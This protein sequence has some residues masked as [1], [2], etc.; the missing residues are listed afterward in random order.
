[1]PIKRVR[2]E[3]EFLR[4]TH[5][6]PDS[7]VRQP[8]IRRP[9]WIGFHGTT[10]VRAE[11]IEAEGVIRAFKALSAEEIGVLCRVGFDLIDFAN[12]RSAFDFLLQE[13]AAFSRRVGTVNFFSVSDQALQHTVTRGGQGKEWVL[14]PLVAEVLGNKRFAQTNPY[15]ADLERMHQKLAAT[16][17]T[18]VVYAVY[19]KGL[20]GMWLHDTQSAIQVNGPIPIWRIVAR[21]DA[22]DFTNYDKEKSLIA[23]IESRRLTRTKDSKHF[24]TKLTTDPPG[25]PG[26]IA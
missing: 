22:P 15:R 25:V 20:D 23:K 8:S 6:F 16:D 17:G 4:N 11:Q 24:T 21:L 7:V 3:P 18:P 14:K 13:A 19:L 9:A 10:T 2:L 26:K 12:D 1:M 5:V